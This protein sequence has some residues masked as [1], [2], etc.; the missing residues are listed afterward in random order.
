MKPH[1]LG[2]KKARIIINAVASVYKIRG[3]NFPRFWPP[4]FIFNLLSNLHMTPPTA[5][6]V[7]SI[8]EY[9]VQSVDDSLLA[10]EE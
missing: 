5:L 8:F 4:Q 10:Q 9:D 7:H 6:S 1:G 2:F 3:F